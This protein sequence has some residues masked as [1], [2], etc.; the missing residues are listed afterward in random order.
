MTLFIIFTIK[1]QEKDEESVSYTTDSHTND[2]RF[3]D[4]GTNSQ[5]IS[6][7]NGLNHSN[8]E[9]H[10]GDDC[11]ATADSAAL[12]KSNQEVMPF[13]SIEHIFLAIGS[14]TLNEE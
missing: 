2:E 10:V 12:E 13:V 6:M 11:G 14:V 5:I 8:A 3:E 4:L 9:Q 7:E 1:W